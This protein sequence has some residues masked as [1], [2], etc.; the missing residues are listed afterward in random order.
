MMQL[1]QEGAG[2][3]G[4]SGMGPSYPAGPQVGQ[5]KLMAHGQFW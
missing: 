1:G 2:M 3:Q 5:R 4:H